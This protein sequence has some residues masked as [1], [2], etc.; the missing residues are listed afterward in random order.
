MRDRVWLLSSV[1]L[2][3][4]CMSTGLEM[5]RNSKL[6]SLWEDTEKEKVV[7]LEKSEVV[8]QVIS[9]SCFEHIHVNKWSTKVMNIFF[10][11][12]TLFFSDQI[13]AIRAKRQTSSGPPVIHGDF[14][15]NGSSGH[16]YAQIYYSGDNSPVS[17]C[18]YCILCVV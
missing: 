1:L 7:H 5:S 9:S 8:K 2:V 10:V 13:N 11:L 17:V 18:R 3:S 12:L 15:F 6:R 14:P 16:L 4:L